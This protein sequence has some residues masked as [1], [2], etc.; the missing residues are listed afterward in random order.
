MHCSTRP[1]Q[2]SIKYDVIIIGSYVK[3]SQLQKSGFLCVKIN[4]NFKMLHTVLFVGLV[5]I[6]QNE[7]ETIFMLISLYGKIQKNRIAT[8]EGILSHCAL[9]LVSRSNAFCA[10]YVASTPRYS[11]RDH[12]FRPCVYYRLISE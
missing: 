1:V 6:H 8:L 9:V 10:M 3:N 7:D 11:T 2:W 5:F 4:P 12:W